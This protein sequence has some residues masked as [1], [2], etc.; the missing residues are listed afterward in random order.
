LQFIYIYDKIEK[1][2]IFKNKFMSE[3]KNFDFKEIPKI[4]EKQK[5]LN[6]IN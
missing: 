3:I 1:I 2:I 4:D 6:E 5:D